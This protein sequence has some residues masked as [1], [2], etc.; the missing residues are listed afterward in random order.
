MHLS[1]S[2][3]KRGLHCNK[4][5]WLST[6]KYDLGNYEKNFSALIGDKVGI[7]ATEIYQNGKM[8]NT[9]FNKHEEAV[10]I[11]LSLMSNL[12]VEA[13]FEAAFS[14]D[15]INIRVDILERLE[16]NCW[17]I[18]EVKSSK[19]I[20]ENFFHDISI[21]YFV[22]KKLNYQIS[23]AQIMY[24][25]GDYVLNNNVIEWN[26][27]FLKSEYKDLIE[28]NIDNVADNI[29]FLKNIQTSD[30]EPIASPGKSFCSGCEF[31]DYCT[32]DKPK[33]WIA[34]IPRLH[35]SKKRVLD[36]KQ[37]ESISK[38]PNDFPFT[39]KQQ[40]VVDS[41][42]TNQIFKTK[43]FYYDLKKFKP[44]IYFFDFETLSCAIP[45]IDNTKPFEKLPFQWSLHHLDSNK[46][47]NHWEFLATEIKDYRKEC[48]EKL[49]NIVI[50]DNSKIVAYNQ[51]FEKSVLKQLGDIFPELIDPIN[52]IIDRIID[53]E[54]FIKD[55][56]YH[57]EFQGSYSLKKVLPALL[58]NEK[59]YNEGNV[60]DGEQAQET[61]Y[62]LLFQEKDLK[63]KE[64]IISSLLEYCKKDTES[65]LLIYQYFEKL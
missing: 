27:F 48:I 44:P 50:K 58:P 46:N 18:R 62:N 65:L 26:K 60:S 41:T 64:L 30:E 33:D 57:P 20:K 25:N 52:N 43:K 55:N 13:I 23:S 39:E 10:Q 42:K 56:Y 8:V 61:F 51:S 17:G 1:K 19:S 35:K 31:W 5:L 4:Q 6:H 45:T 21:Q 16:N 53:L 29:V 3:Y 34:N 9:P 32:K 12:K 14:Y 7:G 63:K 15:N 22:L 24:V 11:T 37:I 49:I 2:R 54:V 36:D 28:D 47:V 40:I 38:I 59:K